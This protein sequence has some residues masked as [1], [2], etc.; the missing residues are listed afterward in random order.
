MLLKHFVLMSIVF[1]SHE[2]ARSCDQCY[3]AGHLI[4]VP[5][6]LWGDMNYIE[7]LQYINPTMNPILHIYSGE[8][9][10]P[11]PPHQLTEDYNHDP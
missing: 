3:T 8:G 11:D 7:H 6:R 2:V 4:S 1:N 10:R 5:V 9:F